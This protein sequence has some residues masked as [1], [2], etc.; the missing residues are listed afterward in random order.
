M[1]PG[2]GGTPFW[3]RLYFGSFNCNQLEIS[4]YCDIETGQSFSYSP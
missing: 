1:S 3:S 2:F 4:G